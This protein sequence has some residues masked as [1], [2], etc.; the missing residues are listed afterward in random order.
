[1]G[2]RNPAGPKCLYG[3]FPGRSS[4]GRVARK[5]VVRAFYAGPHSAGAMLDDEPPSIDYQ[6]KRDPAHTRGDIDRTAATP[7]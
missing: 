7:Y 5:H 1:M 2:P 4:R 6:R 3:H